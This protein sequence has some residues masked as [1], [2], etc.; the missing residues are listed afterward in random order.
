MSYEIHTI[1]QK[2][3][4]NPNE[5]HIQIFTK[6]EYQYFEQLYSISNI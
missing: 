6:Y 4:L 3:G 1:K 2:K 5:F